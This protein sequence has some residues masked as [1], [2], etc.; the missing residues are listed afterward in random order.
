MLPIGALSPSSYPRGSVASR[1]RTASTQRRSTEPSLKKGG[2]LTGR[3]RRKPFTRSILLL[4][5]NRAKLPYRSKK[6]QRLAWLEQSAKYYNWKRVDLKV[7]LTKEVLLPVP[8][9]TYLLLS[10]LSTKRKDRYARRIPGLHGRATKS[11][12]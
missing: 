7:E 11:F 8:C 6:R 10:I 4:N 5:N 2:Q 12:L 9:L 1:D 3:E